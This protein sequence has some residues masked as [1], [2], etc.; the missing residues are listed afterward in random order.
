MGWEVS[1]ALNWRSKVPGRG[2]CWRNWA[3]SAR[4]NLQGDVCGGTRGSTA[5][6]GGRCRLRRGA[7]QIVFSKDF[8]PISP[9]PQAL[10]G[11]W[12]SRVRRWNFCAVPS[13][14]G[15]PVWLSWPMESGT[16]D[17][18]YFWAQVRGAPGT[19]ALCPWVFTPGT[20]PPCWEKGQAP[21]RCSSLST[22]S[23]FVY[24]SL[25]HFS[26]LSKK[27]I[28]VDGNDDDSYYK[29]NICMALTTCQALSDV[30]FRLLSPH[31]SLDICIYISLCV[32]ID[33]WRIMIY[34]L[35]YI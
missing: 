16:R 20:R 32:Y 9:I 6:A 28:F 35:L 34:I 25:G 18:K 33:V 21:C 14:L 29:A 26:H 5:H 24:I 19:C 10:L 17:A 11:P 27:Q 1:R 3:D 31:I 23:H 8:Y 15:W 13:N 2:G 30:L 7:Q 22:V 4:R 12:Q